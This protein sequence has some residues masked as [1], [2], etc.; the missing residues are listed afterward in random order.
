MGL[1]RSHTTMTGITPWIPGVERV[2][3]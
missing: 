2:A 1:D 3:G